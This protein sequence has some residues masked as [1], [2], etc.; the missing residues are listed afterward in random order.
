MDVL[1]SKAEEKSSRIFSLE[2]LKYYC[3]LVGITK[4]ATTLDM[5]NVQGF[6]LYKGQGNYQLVPSI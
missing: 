5:L 3:E 1:K 6:L 2:E 4:V